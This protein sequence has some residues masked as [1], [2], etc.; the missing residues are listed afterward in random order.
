MPESKVDPC[1]VRTVANI[2]PQYTGAEL[3]LRDSFG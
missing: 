2:W 3:S 1:S